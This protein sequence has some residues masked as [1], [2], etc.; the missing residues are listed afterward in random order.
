MRVVLDTNILISAMA[1]RGGSPGR[2]L[3]HW[4]SHKFDL[5]T[6]EFQIDELRQAS[7][8]ARLASRL[9]QPE[10]GRLVNDLRKAALLI[11]RLPRVDISPDPDDNYLLAIAEAGGAAFIVSGDKT[12]L[13]SLQQHGISRI[14]TA[15]Q[16]L[17]RIEG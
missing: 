16:F 9:S 6:H 10:V 8:Y 1:S 11:H 17:T 2:V 3:D 4:Y 14:V 7:R 12:D 13:L 15:R 5:L